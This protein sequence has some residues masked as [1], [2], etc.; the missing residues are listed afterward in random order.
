MLIYLSS[1][2]DANLLGS[3]YLKNETIETAIENIKEEIGGLPENFS[4]ARH[5]GKV[6]IPINPKQMS[7]RLLDIFRSENDVLVVVPLN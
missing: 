1:R 5:N 6:N 3:V 4:I 2:E 7:K